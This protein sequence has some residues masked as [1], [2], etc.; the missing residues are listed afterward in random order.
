MTS[1][2]D[3]L[4]DASHLIWRLSLAKNDLREPLPQGPV[5]ID[6][7]ETQV[8]ERSLAYEL[9]HTLLRISRIHRSLLHGLEKRKELVG[10]HVM[11]ADF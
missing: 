1:R 3:L 9:K 2:G 8:L 5:V 6:P 4:G 7:G 11:G 10:G